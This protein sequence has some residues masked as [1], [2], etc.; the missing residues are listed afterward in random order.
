[1]LWCECERRGQRVGVFVSERAVDGSRAVVCVCVCVCVCACVCANVDA[2]GHARRTFSAGKKCFKMRSS[3]DAQ[4]KLS[5]PARSSSVLRIAH[6]NWPCGTAP[7]TLS[8]P[9]CIP[10]TLASPP[11]APATLSMA[12]THTEVGF[13]GWANTEL[14][15]GLG[16]TPWAKDI[17]YGGMQE[18]QPGMQPVKGAV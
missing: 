15:I 17:Q 4:R 3:R 12:P 7:N 9:P 13:R 6:P 1:V 8:T 10:T 16:R 11:D 18:A 2:D 5:L 14:D